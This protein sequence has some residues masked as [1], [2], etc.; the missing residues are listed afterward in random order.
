MAQPFAFLNKPLVL[1]LR[2]PAPPEEGDPDRP[3][4]K[5]PKKPHCRKCGVPMKDHQCPHKKPREEEGGDSGAARFDSGA[6]RVDYD[7]KRASTL[8]PPE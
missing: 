1:E 5:K 3:Q 8:V 7:A 2:E 4:S 6:A